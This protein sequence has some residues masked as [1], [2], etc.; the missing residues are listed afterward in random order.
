MVEANDDR[1]SWR[2]EAGD[3]VDRKAKFKKLN[4]RRLAYGAGV[5]ARRVGFAA[6]SDALDIDKGMVFAAA[7]T[8]QGR[9]PARRVVDLAHDRAAQ[10]RAL[11]DQRIISWTC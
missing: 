8:R 11:R 10:L 5:F 3:I 1:G 2:L 6:P 7:E 4:R 9:G